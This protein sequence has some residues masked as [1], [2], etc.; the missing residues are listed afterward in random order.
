MPKKSNAPKKR[1]PLRYRSKTL[2]RIIGSVLKD[3]KFIK[4]E[5]EEQVELVLEPLIDLQLERLYRRYLQKCHDTGT[6][7]SY[8]DTDA[9]LSYL[10]EKSPETVVKRV[11]EA[12]VQ[13]IG[14]VY[15]IKTL[16]AKKGEDS[17]KGSVRARVQRIR[18]YCDSIK[19]IWAAVAIVCMILGAAIAPLFIDG[20][21]QTVWTTMVAWI[22]GKFS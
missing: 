4:P 21:Y 20:G 1:T 3:E 19:A 15:R 22:T 2:Q 6:P 16:E 12:I 11:R 17:R 7:A 9:Y 18:E 10:F 14:L 8:H 5:C 13:A